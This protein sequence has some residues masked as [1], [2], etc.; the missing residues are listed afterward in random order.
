[1][2]TVYGVN[3]TKALDPKSTNT[4]V[5]GLIGGKVRVMSDSYEASSLA[6]G[7][8]I[9]VGHTLPVGAT[10]LRVEVAC[11][12]LG[13]ATIDVGDADDTNR[14]LSAQSVASA[15]LLV[16]DE[17]DGVGYTTDGTDDTQIQITTASASI[18][19]TLRVNIYYVFG[20]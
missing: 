13:S 18:T 12:A 1:M 19:G 6:S 11:D 14:Y 15:A 17:T 4:I 8:V 20:D 2:A 3:R 5:G 9:E 7:S 10:V 16:N